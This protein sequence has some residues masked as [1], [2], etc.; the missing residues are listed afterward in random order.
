VWVPQ[1]NNS[2]RGDWFHKE[3]PRQVTGLKADRGAG[4]HKRP[5]RSRSQANTSELGR[6]LSR[7]PF[8]QHCLKIDN[9]RLFGTRLSGSCKSGG[10]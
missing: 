10:F 9:K 8:S 7:V 5:T 6:H 1:Q 2:R 4:I 3:K